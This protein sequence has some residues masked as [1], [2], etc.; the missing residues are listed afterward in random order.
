MALIL[1]LQILILPGCAEDEGSTTC[2]D[3]LNQKQYSSV[4]NDRRCSNYERASGYLGMAGF[5]FAPFLD[6]RGNQN[7][8]R[9]M[10]LSEYDGVHKDLDG[11]KSDTGV[12]RPYEE[13]MCLVGP[14]KLV[15]SLVDQEKCS[16]SG[17]RKNETSR[18]RLDIEIFIFGILGELALRT[19]GELDRDRN[20]EISS[21]ELGIFREATANIDLETA[22]TAVFSSDT[23]IFQALTDSS[24]YMVKLG[25]SFFGLL[26]KCQDMNNSF[27]GILPSNFDKDGS[28]FT[29]LNLLLSELV[30]IVKIDEVTR[31]FTQESGQKLS[32]VFALTS[33]YAE[34]AALMREDLITLGFTPE[35]DFLDLMDSVVSDMD[36]GGEC[37][38]EDNLGIFSVLSE[39]GKTAATG[40]DALKEKNLLKLTTLKG[41]RSVIDV[42]QLIDNSCPKLFQ[43][44]CDTITH[45]RMIYKKSDGSYTDFYPDAIED[46]IR[47]PLNVF[48]KLS[49]GEPVKDDEIITFQELMCFDSDA[50]LNNLE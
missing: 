37:L 14:Q 29:C 7:F 10:G 36:N 15:D 41:L 9:I 33:T 39:M 2:K 45:V 11:W 4:A 6:A 30:P 5:G 23:T 47:I 46:R 1:G 34:R 49:K 20:G 31:I 50:F 26:P 24:V 25:A 13:A 16:V 40:S 48:G 19:F 42:Q 21:T 12:L 18:S 22:N 35:K 3:R 28:S 44:F 43:N 32:S 38:S 8:S 17:Y 27:S